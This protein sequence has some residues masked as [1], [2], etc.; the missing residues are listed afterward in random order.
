MSITMCHYMRSVKKSRTSKRGHSKTPH[1]TSTGKRQRNQALSSGTPLGLF[2]VLPR[3]MRFGIFGFTRPVD[4][5]RLSLTSRKF[6]D[7]VIDFIHN[8]DA[9]PII[10]PKVHLNDEKDSAEVFITME[11]E[12]CCNHFKQLGI[13]L[14][15]ATCL[16]STKERLKEVGIILDKLKDTHCKICTILGSDIAYSCYGKFLHSFVAGWEDDEKF[17]AYLAIK[18]AS[19]L[20]DRIRQ[21]LRS[22]PGSQPW[23]ERYIRVFC[24]EIFLDKSGDLN[25][26]GFWLCKILKPWPLVFQ[27]RLLYIIYGPV[28]E[29]N[30]TIDWHAVEIC[31][32][33]FGVEDAELQELATAL[34]ILHFHCGN[35]EWNQ[36]D[37]LSVFEELTGIP[38]DWCMENVAKL[39]KLCGESVCYDVLG[40]KAMNGR[41]HEISYLGYYLGQV[42]GQDDIMYGKETGIESFTKTVK[43]LL[44]VIQSNKD[45]TTLV[46]S[47]F[48]VWEENILSLGEGM[49]DDVDVVTPEEQEQVF[50]A[51]VHNLCKMA[52]LLLQER[53]EK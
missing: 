46:S 33:F 5:G 8:S 10:V 20:D 19:C 41:I 11:T 13:L 29:D 23:H 35:K 39:L 51:N 43:Q 28:N 44:S 2:G 38:T 40:N 15:R 16:F 27:A 36:D 22:T 12:Y 50:A 30:G 48:N 45:Q 42:L 37:F 4:L 7:E 26:T 6:R 32:T 9:L 47:L 17:K 34:K 3:E 14:K 52:G 1:T 31:P 49:H 25:E 18:G 53:A 21:V 24:R